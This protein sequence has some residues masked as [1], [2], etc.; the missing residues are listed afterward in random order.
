MAWLLLSFGI[1]MATYSLRLENQR[2]FTNGL[3]AISLTVEV[4]DKRE[5]LIILPLYFDV[6]SKTNLSFD[7]ILEKNNEFSF[8]LKNFNNR[9][10]KDKSLECMGYVLDFDENNNPIYQRTW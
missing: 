5:L 1:R 8:I 3:L 6:Q 9:D 4:L 7:E 2:Y 10:E